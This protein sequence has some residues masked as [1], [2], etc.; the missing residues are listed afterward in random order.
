[1]EKIS[2]VYEI[3]NTKTGKRYIGSSKNYKRRKEEH[4]Y[5]LKRGDH[6]SIYLQNSFDKNGIESFIFNILELV[7]DNKDLFN[8][9]QFYLDKYSS[10]KRAFGY[11]ICS[12][13]GKS[14]GLTRSKSSEQKRIQSILGRKNSK[15]T[16]EKMSNSAKKRGIPFNHRLKMEESR[17]IFRISSLPENS[18]VNTETIPKPGLGSKPYKFSEEVIQEI[19]QLLLQGASRTDLSKLYNCSKSTIYRIYKELQ[20]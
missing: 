1:M 16:I 17:G 14:L 18:V 10:Y 15:E 19:K 8:K 5:L 2:C 11:N 20:V 3:L 12:V 6:S 13:A 7:E 4:I 9:E